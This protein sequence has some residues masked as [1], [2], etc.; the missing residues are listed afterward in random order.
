MISSDSS[1]NRIAGFQPN[2]WTN[3]LVAL[4]AATAPGLVV[5]SG[6]PEEPPPAE[7]PKEPLKFDPNKDF[8]RYKGQ[9]LAFSDF[10]AVSAYV[11]ETNFTSFGSEEAAY[12]ETKIGPAKGDVQTL[13]LRRHGED[14]P[15]VC[16]FNRTQLPV[17]MQKQV[18]ENKVVWAYGWFLDSPSGEAVLE[19][20]QRRMPP[21]G[22][23]FGGGGDFGR[24]GRGRG[25]G[26][27]G[28]WLDDPGP[29]DRVR[30]AKRSFQLLVVAPPETRQ[31]IE[32]LR[33]AAAVKDA[34]APVP[35]G[36]SFE[37]VVEAANKGSSPLVDVEVKLA[38]AASESFQSGQIVDSLWIDFPRIPPRQTVTKTVT[39]LNRSPGSIAPKVRAAAT[40]AVV[41]KE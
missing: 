8:I 2:P 10:K 14:T 19:E 39:L 6:E 4:I 1:R 34:A 7:K 22:G 21:R 13:I 38:A 29:I 26:G 11:D 32:K 41:A 20:L 24:G 37:V 3:L 9:D 5:G 16:E 18:K 27:F 33:V 28:G 36:D 35:R 12:V 17:R 40:H 23:G 15:I 30:E 25:R 31:A